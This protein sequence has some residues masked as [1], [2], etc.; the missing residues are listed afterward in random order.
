MLLFGICQNILQRTKIE[1]F[2]SDLL[3]VQVNCEMLV[4]ISESSASGLSFLQLLE[5]LYLQTKEVV[6]VVSGMTGMQGG[7]P[8]RSNSMVHYAP[9][10]DPSVL[11]VLMGELIDA[12][13]I[14]SITGLE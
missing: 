1:A 12:L 8:M 11:V 6:E 5:P 7:D 9:S 10:F 13:N 4:S 14:Y 3:A 2:S